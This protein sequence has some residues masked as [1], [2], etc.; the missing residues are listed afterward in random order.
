MV[1][2]TDYRGDPDWLDWCITA[3]QALTD[4]GDQRGQQITDEL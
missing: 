4:L 2:C 3:A 1:R